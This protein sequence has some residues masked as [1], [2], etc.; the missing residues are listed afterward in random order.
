MQIVIY[1]L[2]LF[3]LDGPQALD[4][5]LGFGRGVVVTLVGVRF[6]DAEGEEGEREELED[7]GF[8]SLRRHFWKQRV[9]GTSFLVCGRI[10]GSEGAFY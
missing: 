3:D 2:L 4:S 6:R 8:G 7:F 10:D 9:L 5:F 1:V